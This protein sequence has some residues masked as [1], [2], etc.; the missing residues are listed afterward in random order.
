[1]QLLKKTHTKQE[2]KI[3][4]ITKHSKERMV[5]RD[6]QVMDFAEAKRIAKIAFRSGNT[7]NDYQCCPKFA[8]YLR[9]KKNQTSECAVRVYH[10]NIF[11]WRGKARALVT[12]HPIPD[13]F[14]TELIAKGKMKGSD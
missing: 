6:E 3:L 10:D 14:H 4:Q 13:R 11:I 1:M 5:E 12:V 9:R 2:D 8:E 7:I